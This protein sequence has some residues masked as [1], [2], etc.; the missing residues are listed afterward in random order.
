MTIFFE[1]YHIH[2]PSS[3]KNW[4][5]KCDIFHV[6]D[7]KILKVLTYLNFKFSLK[8]IVVLLITKI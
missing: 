5:N 6:F 3:C 4:A 8:I 7:S 1:K 2:W